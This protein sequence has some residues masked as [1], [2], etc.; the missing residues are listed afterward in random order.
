MLALV[1][2]ENSQWMG[3]SQENPRENLLRPGYLAYTRRHRGD[4][5]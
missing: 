1:G 4:R 2:P 3:V 5:L